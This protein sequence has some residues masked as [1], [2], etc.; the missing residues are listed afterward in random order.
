[1]AWKVDNTLTIPSTVTYNETHIT[2]VLSWPAVEDFIVTLGVT[3]VNVASVVTRT[4][5]VEVIGIKE[6]VGPVSPM[7]GRTYNL[8][9]GAVQKSGANIAFQWTQE[10]EIRQAGS[11]HMSNG[12]VRSVLPVYSVD[13]ASLGLYTCTATYSGAVEGQTTATFHLKLTGQCEVPVIAYGGVQHEGVYID[14]DTLVEVFCD[15][16]Y[17]ASAETVRCVNGVFDTVMPICIQTSSALNVQIVSGLGVLIIVVIVILGVVWAV[18]RSNRPIRANMVTPSNGFYGE[19]LKAN[20]GRGSEVH[21]NFA[22]DRELTV[23]DVNYN[24]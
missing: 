21:S 3:Q 5:G 15:N 6:I 19:D 9:C 23:V 12:M 4:K 20:L 17:E 2:S 8:T 7:L 14:T 22:A 16:G 18:K 24:H 1:M 11:Q 10:G 13:A